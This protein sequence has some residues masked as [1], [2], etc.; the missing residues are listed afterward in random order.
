LS[1]R[2]RKINRANAFTKTECRNCISTAC[3]EGAASNPA[4]YSRLKP[5]RVRIKLNVNGAASLAGRP[6]VGGFRA[7]WHSYNF[8]EQNSTN[9]REEKLSVRNQTLHVSRVSFIHQ[10]QFLQ[11]AHTIRPLGAQQMPLA[12]MRTHNFS[13]LRNLETLCRASMGL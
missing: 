13:V 5:L 9:S 1:E 10:R 2:L 7:A 3:L 6:A 4:D 8:V 12:G 11:A